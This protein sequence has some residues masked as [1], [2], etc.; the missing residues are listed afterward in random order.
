MGG[1]EVL[2]GGLAARREGDGAEAFERL[3]LQLPDGVAVDE[4]LA[5]EDPDAQFG[6]AA[7]QPVEVRADVGAERGVLG[8]RLDTQVHR[9]G[10]AAGGRPVRGG[11]GGRAGDGRV[12]GVDL[13]ESGAVHASGPGGEFGEVAEVAHAPGAV[14]EQR[15]ELDEQAPGAGLG[16]ADVVRG[17][18]EVAGG[19]A[20]VGRGGLDP[21]DAERYGPQHVGG[22]G[23]ALPAGAGR[24]GGRDQ[25]DGPVPG[26]RRGLADGG[27]AA[28][29][30]A[31]VPAA[32]GGGP[33]RDGVGVAG[34]AD[35]GARGQCRQLGRGARVGRRGG[36]P[37]HHGGRQQ[38][39][40]L[41]GFGFLQG[42]PDRFGAARVDAEGGQGGH[43]GGFGG[44]N[45]AVRGG[46]VRGGDTMELG[47]PGQG[48]F[49]LLRKPLRAGRPPRRRRRPR[50]ARWSAGRCRAGVVR[51]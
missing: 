36:G 26:G 9:V 48:Q 43:D 28:D 50:P 14:R 13:D 33:G 2:V 7:Q 1:G 10:E 34:Q 47:E 46:G 17:D 45:G 42:G 49:S 44:R 16:P 12:Q 41:S 25:G 27:G 32:R 11:V 22:G 4:G 37:E 51:W 23:R 8:D 31:R 19:G 38:A 20:S 18:D 21:V 3:A 30:L 35:P 39:V 24:G 15:V 29:R 40:G 6:G 5:G